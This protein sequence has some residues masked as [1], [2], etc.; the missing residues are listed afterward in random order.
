M[1][2]FLTLLFIVCMLFSIC[3]CS[4]EY[5]LY[6][7]L[8]NEFLLGESVSDSG[9]IIT[10]ESQYNDTAQLTVED[11]NAMNNGDTQMVFSDDG[12]LTFLNGK[13]Y[14]NKVEDQE[15]AVESIKGIAALI[16]LG[17][18]SD[19]FCEYGAR[20]PNGYCIYT[21]K[22]RYGEQTIQYGTLRVIVDPDGYTAG[23]AC[24][25]TPNIGRAEEVE[26]IPQETAEQ[27]VLNTYE[28][29]ELTVYSEYTEKVAVT[30]DEVVYSAYV[31][32][33]NNFIKSAVTAGMPYLEH[34]VSYDGR[35]LNTLSTATVAS[36]TLDERA[37][38]YFEG[39]E[40]S[41][42]TGTVTLCDGSTK[43]VTVPI[44]YSPQDN[45]YYLMDAE[46]K[47]AVAD[48]A[49]FVYQGFVNFSS[50]STGKDWDN[51]HLIAYSN[52]MEVYDFFANLGI[53]SVDGTGVPILI[54]C[55]WVDQNGVPYNNACNMGI[56]NGFNVFGASDANTFTEA[57]DVCAHEYTH[58]ITGYSMGGSV[59][60][61]NTGAINEA[62]S[63]ILG[64]IVEMSLGR[65]YDT[66][67]WLVGEMSGA[68]LRSMSDPHASNPAQPV[69][70]SDPNFY[71]LIPDEYM[72]DY[73]YVQNHDNGGVH[74]NNSLLSQM[75]Y[76]LFA[77]GMSY[78]EQAWL[79]ITSI[80]LMTP[81][82][83][84]E[85][86]YAALMMSM[87]MNGIDEKYEQ[88]LTDAFREAQLIG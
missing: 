37:L 63:D 72:N 71:P 28:G 36:D 31:V 66:S 45:M 85:E 16:G 81:L 51:N 56:I 50:S 64:N 10:P 49:S 19:F 4:T 58:G 42:Y 15:D 12:Y 38:N 70:L 39:M 62:Y 14:E 1:K 44:A 79:W 55:D 40:T 43:Q 7:L 75:A 48:Y 82:S 52:Y 11:I 30:V 23:F 25:F 80:E 32:Y 74:I 46:R 86:V 20:D 87:E 53:D 84:Y 67:Q 3:G 69:S 83:E 76:K 17:K 34:Y 78:E 21:F 6:T 22:Q 26:W 68:A 35:L 73:D 9:E 65:T 13:Y 57:I 60:L 33:T 18:G 24:S 5:E 27:I 47:I 2:R 77:A 88:I 8:P 29:K 54:C 59:Y 61:N 41:S